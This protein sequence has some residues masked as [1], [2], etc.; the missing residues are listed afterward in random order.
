MSCSRGKASPDSDTKL[1]LFADSGGYCQKPDCN[2]SLFLSIEEENIHIAEMAHIIGVADAAPRSV[3]GISDAAKGDY[4]N[5]IL[6]CPSCHTLIDKAQEHYP[7]EILIEWK[8]NHVERINKIF[9]V[10]KYE[11][12][13]EARKIIVRFLNE[14]NTI[15]ETYG[16]LNDERFNPESDSPKYWL[17][18]IHNNIL[19]NNRNILRIIDCN[20]EL[21]VDNEIPT[22]ELFRQHVND[23]ESKHLNNSELNGIQF[24]TKLNLIF[25]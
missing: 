18:K 5:L 21:L 7:I 24:P 6:L 1:R 14:N 2:K 15:F 10:Q 11:N 9:N 22:V 23:F 12:R 3:V 25:S 16:P 4:S 20:Y 8:K 13:S 17:K 19:P